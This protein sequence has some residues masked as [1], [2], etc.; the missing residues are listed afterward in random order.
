MLFRGTTSHGSASEF[1]VLL[2]RD[3]PASSCPSA[4]HPMEACAGSVDGSPN[5]VMLNWKLNMVLPS[6]TVVA[7]LD[8]VWV[9]HIVSKERT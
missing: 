3:H 2:T 8:C 4:Q 6:N 5:P 1:P 9:G 7:F